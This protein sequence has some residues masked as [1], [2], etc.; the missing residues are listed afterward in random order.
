MVNYT[1]DTDVTVAL[2]DKV[3]IDSTVVF[4]SEL[5]NPKVQFKTQC[6]YI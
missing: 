3:V 6:S 5:L 1:E 2:L 4:N